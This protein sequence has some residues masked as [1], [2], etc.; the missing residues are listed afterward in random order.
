MQIKMEL[1]ENNNLALDEIQITILVVIGTDC[2]GRCQSNYHA[3]FLT[4]NSFH[5][6]H[7]ILQPKIKL[8]VMI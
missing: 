1:L 6:K 5:D 8:T 7:Y 4:E 2:I 3:G